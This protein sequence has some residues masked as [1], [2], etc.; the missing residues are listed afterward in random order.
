MVAGQTTTHQIDHTQ[1]YHRLAGCRELF[2]ILAESAIPA[3]P[4]EGAF[5]HPAAREYFEPRLLIRA[6]DDLERPAS[7]AFNP[8]NQLTGIPA[9]RPDQEEANKL[10]F[11]KFQDQF[12]SIPVLDI[13]RM[14]D[15][16]QE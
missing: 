9:I 7:Q 1:E 3:Q 10:S 4:T 2:V 13:G 12:G 16:R 11:Q 6:F 8:I 5:D 14:D 15:Y